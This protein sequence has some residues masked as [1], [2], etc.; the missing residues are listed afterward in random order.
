MIRHRRFAHA[1]A[2]WALFAL[3]TLASS[4]APLAAQR[5]VSPLVTY[6][7]WVVLGAAAGM[8]VLA[9]RAHDRAD[10]AY[11]ELR[12]RCVPDP[13]L[14]DLAPNGRYLDPGSEALYQRSLRY[15]RQ[16]R[17]WLIAGETA[18]LGAA[19]MFVWELTRPK[20]P[21]ENIPFEPEVSSRDG[22]TRLGLR[23]AF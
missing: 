10:D 21:P 13:D 8:N 12:R 1:P 11:D 22:R 4:A 3:A 17:A 9:A 16:A 6:G 15:D 23:V 14:C 18:L 7:K 19:V 20:G 2:R 5:R